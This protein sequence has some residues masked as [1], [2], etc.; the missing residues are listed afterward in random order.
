MRALS[1]VPAFLFAVVAVSGLTT[2]LLKVM[3]GRARPKLL[4]AAHLYG[5]DGFALRP[6]YWS[7]PSGHA[8]TIIALAAALTILWPRHVL[9]YAF[10]AAI[11]ALGRVVV[12]AHYPSDVMAG[13]FI[14]VVTTHYV[15]VL[16]ERAGIDLAAAKRGIALGTQPWPCRRA[17]GRGAIPPEE[18]RERAGLAGRV[19]A[20]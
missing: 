1:A 5:F 3:I 12:G 4:F 8:T 16:F 15:A 20:R 13:A 10:F 18:S 7:F 2:D 9:F 17:W 14:A 6:D 19:E 11:V